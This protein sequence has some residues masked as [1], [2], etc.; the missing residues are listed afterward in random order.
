MTRDYREQYILLNRMASRKPGHYQFWQNWDDYSSK[1]S[2]RWLRSGRRNDCGTEKRRDRDHWHDELVRKIEA[3][4]YNFLFGKSNEYLQLPR[5]WSSFCRSFLDPEASPE[6]TRKSPAKEHSERGS[7]FDVSPKTSSEKVE[8]N[9]NVKK[10]YTIFS[11]NENLEFNPISGRMRPAEQ[12]TIRK[13]VEEKTAAGTNKPA[14]LSSE[15]RSHKA[16]S[17]QIGESQVGNNNVLYMAGP[18]EDMSTDQTKS[19]TG[20]EKQEITQKT[21]IDQ[22]QKPKQR[23]SYNMDQV[24]E[25]DVDLLR[26]SDIRA[27][28]FAGPTRQEIAEKKKAAR[29][30]LEREYSSSSD[31]QTDINNEILRD[32]KAKKDIGFTTINKHTITK[33]TADAS[34]SQTL[35]NAKQFIDDTNLLTHDIL[36]ICERL[37]ASAAPTDTFR[38]LAY[39]SV[40]SQIVFAETTSSMHTSEQIRHPAEVLLHI[41]NPAKFLPHFA[42]MKADGYEIVSGGGDILIF[43]KTAD[44]PRKFSEETGDVKFDVLPSIDGKQSPT[45]DAAMSGSSQSAPKQRSPDSRIVRRQETVYTGG[46]PNWSPYPPTSS[47]SVLDSESASTSMGDK[48]EQTDSSKRSSRLGRGIRRVILSGF[49][50]AGT[51]YAIGVVCEYFI[52]G[53]KDGLGPE[54][55]SEFE[56]ERRRR[57]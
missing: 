13:Q 33:D 14:S 20:V 29:E 51:F 53:G 35:E 44:E 2:R 46:P 31:A 25:D 3:D 11:H 36:K 6:Q 41:N 37:E 5:R 27:S 8:N 40:S 9:D 49:A 57:D 12:P 15:T 45:I 30:A 18:T 39:D 1:Q 28:F 16:S 47:S 26:A 43:R 10:S 56:A 50:T 42:K 7:A 34:I 17:T 4:P 54:G 23:L 38:V 21:K 48:Q 22:K 32:L 24:K 55:L 19:T 52:T